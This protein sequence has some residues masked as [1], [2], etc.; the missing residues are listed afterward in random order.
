MVED[1]GFSVYIYLRYGKPDSALRKF[2]TEDLY[3]LPPVILLCGYLN[4]PNIRYLN[5]DVVPIKHPF[6]NKVDIESYNINWFEDQSPSRV[7]TFIQDNAIPSISP[8]RAKPF[9][10]TYTWDNA[11]SSWTDVPPSF[12]LPHLTSP[13][14]QPPS[15]VR[16]IIAPTVAPL[17]PSVA[18]TMFGL[19]LQSVTASTYRLFSVSTPRR[20]LCVHVGTLSNHNLIRVIVLL[21]S[22]W[23]PKWRE[24]DWDEDKMFEFGARVLCALRLNP[25]TSKYINFGTIFLSRIRILLG[26]VPLTSLPQFHHQKL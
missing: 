6:D 14:Q 12:L 11:T 10:D 24:I 26:L 22:R 16:S 23:W 2:M 9:S 18:P 21:R 5:S 7:P 1:T 4:T 13:V 3:I 15:V 8:V 19:L 25:D 20:E 17:S